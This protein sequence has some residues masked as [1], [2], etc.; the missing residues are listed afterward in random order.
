[1]V[2]CVHTSLI[3]PLCHFTQKLPPTTRARSFFV[4]GTQS[5]SE[6][7]V[8]CFRVHSFSACDVR[9]VI[10]LDLEIC[11]RIFIL[12]VCIW[13]TLSVIRNAKSTIQTSLYFCVYTV[14]STILLIALVAVA[15][16]LYIQKRDRPQGENG[17]SIMSTTDIN[18]SEE[19]N[20]GG[21]TTFVQEAPGVQVR[22]STR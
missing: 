17:Q 3:V 1:M 20:I 6:P 16:I 7:T 5:T 12:S 15:A 14:P 21:G 18:I 19:A 4:A 8:E 11:W 22:R 2:V 9:C 10:A 13:R